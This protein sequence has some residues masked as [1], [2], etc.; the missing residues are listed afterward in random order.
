MVIAREG[1]VVTGAHYKAIFLLWAHIFKHYRVFWLSQKTQSTT[2][3]CTAKG[4]RNEHWHG[5][6]STRTH[7]K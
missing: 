4:S 6:A 3:K 1:I 7:T 2:R 5:T